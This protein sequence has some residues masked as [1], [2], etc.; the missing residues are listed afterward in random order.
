M[1]LTPAYWNER[2]KKSQTGWDIGYPSTPLVSYIDQLVDKKIKILIPGCGNSY[3][4][5]YLI[6]NDFTNVFVLDYSTA[7][8]AQF[9]KRVP[10]FPED[11]LLTL[12]FFKL[13]DQFDLI[14]EQTFF[15]AL[16][17]SLRDLYVSKM[18]ELIAPGG[19]IAGVLF[20]RIFDKPGPPFGGTLEEYK[21]IFAKTMKIK[22]L[23]P[24]YNSIPERAGNELF[25]IFTN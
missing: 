9:K 7:A 14:L 5:E 13:I 24:C 25:F 17:P 2:Y 1:K 16:D 10:K 21:N 19:K 6:E 20:N 15:C 3:E 23:E 4:A 8:I 22:T 18:K 11:Q 12:D